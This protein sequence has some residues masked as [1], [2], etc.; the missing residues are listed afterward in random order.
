M[1]YLILIYYPFFKNIIKDIINKYKE[2]KYSI[3]NYNK[4]INKINIQIKINKRKLDDLSIT[5]NSHI[6]LV[7]LQII[8][9]VINILNNLLNFFV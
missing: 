4:I 3:F 9:I 5:C 1:Y 2:T 6:I 7:K 8:I